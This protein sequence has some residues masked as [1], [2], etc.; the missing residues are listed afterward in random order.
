[1]PTE[2]CWGSGSG[3]SWR[4][5][6]A[7]TAKRVPYDAHL[8]SFAAKTHK[9]PEL[10]A[11]NPR[12]RVPTVRDGALSLWESLAIVAWLDRKHPEPPLFGRTAEACGLVRRWCLEHDNEAR[13]AIDAVVRPI[14]FDP[15]Q[16][17]EDAIRDALPAA[18]GWPRELDQAV[19][20]GFVVGDTLSHWRE[21]AHPSPARLG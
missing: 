17:K 5:L 12:G 7:F 8:V 13:V 6:L 21:G 15:W 3:P 18:H 2:V 16:G 1:M 19:S 11:M 20:G 10:L 4:V 9:T 14:V